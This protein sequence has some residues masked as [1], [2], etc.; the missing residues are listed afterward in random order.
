M[1]H[2]NPR[3][4][5]LLLLTAMIWGSAFVSQSV[6]MDYVGPFTFL[7]A[8]SYIGSA[9]LLGFLTVQ[10]RMKAP[11]QR[12]ADLVTGNRSA[13]PLLIKAG[14]CAGG[15]LFVASILQQIGI[16]YTTVGK[17]GFLTAMYIIFVPFISLVLFR[18]R[19]PRLIWICVVLSVAGMALLCLK[20]SLSLS[21][22]DS[23]VLLCA[24]AFSG[25]ILVLD[26]F[27]PQV[28]PVR[29]SCIQFLVCALLSTV[30]MLLLEKPT[31]EVL[32]AAAP[33]I[34]YAGV[35]SSGVAY[36]LQAVAQKDCDP[37]LASLVMCLESVFSAVFGWVIL[38]QALS[39]REGV[40]CCLMFAAIA[41]A[42]L[43]ETNTQ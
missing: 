18:K 27:T 5:L 24:V 19:L 20:E 9:F 36:T 13:R 22:G 17:A 1:K 16:A 14:I 8:R 4:V 21:T 25:H 32:L 15:V 35:L 33:S 31:W 11:E 40:G 43:P 7:A 38:H 34:L 39:L 2:S 10:T 12:P 37:T 3:N 23:L 41:L 30:P 28:D 29:M 42:Q 6:G 26:F